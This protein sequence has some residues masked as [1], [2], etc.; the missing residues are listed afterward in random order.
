M[1]SHQILITEDK[2]IPD[3]LH[4]LI[5]KCTESFRQAFPYTD[6][7]LY[8]GEELEEFIKNNFGKE[9]FLSY[10][11]LNAFAYR[12]DLAR[13][14]LLYH[15]GGI[16]SDLLL[17][18]MTSIK[19]Y[20]FNEIDFCAFRD[21]QYL[22]DCGTS[23]STFNIANTI[24][25]SKPKSLVMKK[26]IENIVNNCRRES[27]G[28]NPLDVTGPLVLG[29]ALHSAI[30]EGVDEKCVHLLGDFL[31]LTFGKKKK[32]LAFLANDGT[33][34][35]LKKRTMNFYSS[36]VDGN[37]YNNLYYKKQVY[38]QSIMIP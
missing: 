1:K 2:T 18:Y 6:Y 5:V 3:N 16:Y 23:F 37:E 30:L 25:F 24:L 31:D 20:T 27:Y 10:N 28:V 26:Y 21:R 22:T 29:K 4:P 12:C 7:H 35:A 36:K 34:V 14:C 38:D 8:S 13:A 19:K 33:I 17:Q 15:Y 9:V 32:N 11:K